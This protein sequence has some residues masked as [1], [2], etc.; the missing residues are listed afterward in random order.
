MYLRLISLYPPP[1]LKTVI[2]EQFQANPQGGERVRDVVQQRVVE[3]GREMA[4]QARSRCTQ[5]THQHC[6][7]EVESALALL[8]PPD[9]SPQVV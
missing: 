6:N 4:E 5:L 3:V 9:I 2:E 1:Q 7:G 8:L